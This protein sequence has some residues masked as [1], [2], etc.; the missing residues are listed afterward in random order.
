MPRQGS[1]AEE[2]DI[3]RLQQELKALIPPETVA[4]AKKILA[5][6]GVPELPDGVAHEG[7]TLIRST[8]ATARRHIDIALKR[9]NVR[10]VANAL[11]APPEDVT[12]LIQGSG[13][14]VAGLCGDAAQTRKHAAAGGTSSSPRARKAAAI[15]ARLGRWS[16]GRRWSP[17][18][19]RRRS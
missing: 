10:L 4:F 14:L 15:P 12:R 17:R 1:L 18:S 11:G 16:C 8:A 6:N 19:R 2:P 3:H 5:D 13:R 9:P 7:D